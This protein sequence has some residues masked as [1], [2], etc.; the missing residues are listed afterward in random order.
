MCREFVCATVP[1]PV[2][3]AADMC[4]LK[5]PIED[6]RTTAR[7]EEGGGP[8][9]PDEGNDALTASPKKSVSASS[10][11]SFAAIGDSCGSSLLLNIGRKLPPCPPLGPVLA[12]PLRTLCWP[13]KIGS[14]SVQAK[15]RVFSFT[16]TLLLCSSFAVDFCNAQKDSP[17]RRNALATLAGPITTCVYTA[18]T[19]YTSDPCL[20]P[21]LLLV[22]KHADLM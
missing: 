12:N 8:P 16:C 11:V 22:D 20:L 10:V 6:G 2:V 1:A 7:K 15:L 5:F 19:L 13:L 17:L 3:P 18:Y 21:E 9:P 4:V 14:P